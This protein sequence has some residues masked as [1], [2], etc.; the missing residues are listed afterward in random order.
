MVHYEIVQFSDIAILKSLL[1]SPPV[2]LR[3]KK[4]DNYCYIAIFW[5]A[6]SIERAIKQ[7]TNTK[8]KQRLKRAI[9]LQG[10]ENREKSNVAI[11]ILKKC[12]IGYRIK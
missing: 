2:R 9:T 3:A 4:S 6:I 5:T 10:V 12:K 1:L 7:R 8:I 11:A